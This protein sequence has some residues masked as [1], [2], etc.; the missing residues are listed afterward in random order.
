MRPASSI[1]APAAKPRD[2][3]A[4]FISGAKEKAPMAAMALRRALHAG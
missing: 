1:A 4:F 2:V 3:Y